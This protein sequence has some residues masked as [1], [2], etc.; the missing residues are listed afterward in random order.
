MVGSKFRPA[1][2]WTRPLVLAFGLAAALALSACEEDANVAG[3]SANIQEAT[4]L[5]DLTICEPA[6]G[7]G[8]FL[9][10]AKGTQ[11][12]GRDSMDFKAILEGGGPML[13]ENC[14]LWTQQ[15][16]EQGIEVWFFVHCPYEEHSPGIARRFQRLLEARGAPVPPLPWDQLPP[17]RQAALF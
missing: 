13:K 17:P 15:W 11:H 12:L 2:L 9:N 8:A 5:L 1:S 4:E 10:E 7:S 6:L 3:G 14:K 16:L